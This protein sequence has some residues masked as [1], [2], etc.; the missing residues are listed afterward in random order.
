MFLSFILLCS[1]IV[2]L[3]EFVSGQIADIYTKTI[4]KPTL[5]NDSPGRL[6]MFTLPGSSSKI[7]EPM[8][9]VVNT[10]TIDIP[11]I[12]DTI[13]QQVLNDNSEAIVMLNINDMNSDSNTNIYNHCMLKNDIVNDASVMMYTSIYQPFD[14]SVSHISLDN[15]NINNK[16]TK[17]SSMTM[18]DFLQ[19]LNEQQELSITGKSILNDNIMDMYNVDMNMDMEAM[20]MAM[21]R[22]Q[23][24]SSTLV[25]PVTFMIVEQPQV[26]AF[27]P[28]SLIQMLPYTRRQL[29]SNATNTNTTNI[30]YYQP[31]TGD[32]GN[33]N[34]IYYK[35][36]G[37]EYA[38][39]YADTYLYITPDIFTGIMT[40]LFMFFVLYTGYSCLGSIQGA[41]SF[42]MKPIP[43]GKEY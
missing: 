12:V 14:V 20:K 29:A 25:S 34:S 28:P 35:P 10:H 41:S 42:V 39:Y 40:G 43:N 11:Y 33:I 22:L 26:N 5:E 1:I 23:Q 36:E 30:S 15:L 16:K 9:K 4:P 6:A 19:H 27:L 8:K 31:T 18:S 13:Q 38:I 24:L 32:L 3:Y 17:I 7:E 2:F 21:D 37:G